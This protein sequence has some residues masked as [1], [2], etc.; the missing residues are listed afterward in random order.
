MHPDEYADAD[1]TNY[2]LNGRA[3]TVLLSALP[4][5]ES[6]RVAHCTTANEIWTSLEHTYIGNEK[7]KEAK[8][9]SLILDF[10]SFEMK[11]GENIREMAD[12]LITITSKLQ[13]PNQ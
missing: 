6:N 10:D 7:V 11:S 5:T 1:F 9:D 4:P 12:R 13:T 3:L 8:A 2:M